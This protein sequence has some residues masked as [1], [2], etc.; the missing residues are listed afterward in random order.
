M[1][2]GAAVSAAAMRP[3]TARRTPAEVCASSL[4]SSGSSTALLLLLLLLLLPL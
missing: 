3:H 2:L 1:S 4:L